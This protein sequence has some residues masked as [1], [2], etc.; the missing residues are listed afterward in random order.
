MLISSRNIN[1]WITFVDETSGCLDISAGGD[2]YALPRHHFN[3][4]K[5]GAPQ[6]QSF[7]IVRRVVRAMVK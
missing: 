7:K 5:F 4:N 2:K 6:E 3:I 1:R